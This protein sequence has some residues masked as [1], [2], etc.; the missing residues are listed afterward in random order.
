VSGSSVRGPR[1]L[2]PSGL[3]LV[4]VAMLVPLT[5]AANRSSGV[6]RLVVVGVLSATIADGWLAYRSLRRLDATITTPAV[7]T[8]HRRFGARAV[9]SGSTRAATV[10]GLFGDDEVQPFVPG[11]PFSLGCLPTQRGV[12]HHLLIEVRSRSPLGLWT[13]A[14]RLGVRLPTPLQ[15]GPVARRPEVTA[16][17]GVPGPGGERPIPGRARQPTVTRSVRDYRP[18][19]AVRQVHWPATAHHGHLMVRETEAER[20]PVP[21]VVVACSG[22]G[23]AAE[24]AY[25]RAVEHVTGLL[26]GGDAVRL[27]TVE[28]VPIEGRAV[29]PR[30]VLLPG[31]RLRSTPTPPERVITVDDAVHDPD[32][33]RAR[34]ARAVPAVPDPGTA[35]PAVIGRGPDGRGTEPTGWP[36]A[37]W[38]T[39]EGDHP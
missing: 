4:V 26:A 12:F 17:S 30:G 39:D 11:A 25:G 19:D 10:D 32:D 6:A 14:R 31:A 34:L 28:P 37:W 24:A 36:G 7:A 3:L 1:L 16:P 38:I 33:V 9:I 29:I 23:A 35:E 15:V 18:G 8:S 2:I 22:P 5:T 27:V 21:T 20:R 13:A